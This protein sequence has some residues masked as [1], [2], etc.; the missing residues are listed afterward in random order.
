M[1][2]MI[3]IT[4]NEKS[5]MIKQYG[6]K[7]GRNPVG[8]NMVKNIDRNRWVVTQSV[9]TCKWENE[10]FEKGELENK[11]EQVANNRF[12]LWWLVKPRY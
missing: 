10:E 6:E 11:M 5:K 1:G 12:C 4:K 9:K 2:L 8:D 3:L 7:P